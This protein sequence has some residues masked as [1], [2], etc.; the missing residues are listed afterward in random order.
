MKYQQIVRLDRCY[1]D[2]FYLLEK[3]KENNKLNFKISGSTLNVYSITIDLDSKSII[4]DCPDALDLCK[5]CNISCKHV[6][7]VLLKVLQIKDTL[8]VKEFL[9][10]QSLNDNLIEIIKNLFELKTNDDVTNI[11]L[12]NKYKNLKN[13][14]I[15]HTDDKTCPIC[16]DNIFLS[17][18]KGITQCNCCKKIFHNL[19]INKWFD[20]GKSNCPYCRSTNIQG[21]RYKNLL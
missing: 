1:N 6:C 18:N 2:K 21:S 10:N 9:I 15:I 4:C 8:K 19:C 12:V 17:N 20:I 11:N 5:K 7:F 13:D 16:Y 14:I 3:T